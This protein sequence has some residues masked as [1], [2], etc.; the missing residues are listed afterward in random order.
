MTG[1][2]PHEPVPRLPRHAKD[3]GQ[4]RFLSELNDWIARM[5]I[6]ESVSASAA[7]LPLVYVVGAPRSGTT[8]ASQLL[9]KYLDVGYIDNL[10]ARFWRRPIVGIRLS[11][12]CLGAEARRSISLQSTYGV[13]AGL[14]GP[15]E[16]GYFWRYWFD[17]DHAPTH[18][19][20]PAELERVD[21]DG[22]G[23]VLRH[24]LLGGFDRPTVF[25][26]VI[27]GFQARLLSRVHANSLF[28][29]VTRDPMATAGSILAARLARYGTHNAWWS[30]KPGTFDTIS[31]IAEPAAQVAR[32]V[33][34]CRA[35]LAEELASPGVH[36]ITIGYETLC[37]HPDAQLERVCE[38]VRQLGGDLRPLSAVEP[39]EP[40]SGPN[41]P[42]DLHDALTA[43]F[44]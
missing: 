2:D 43:A 17:L 22:L 30:L 6:D 14:A 21:T 19:L 33:L 40:S 20:T 39:L 4:E 8:L 12:I 11:Q 26:N 44:A 15:H 38:A 10:I 35:E 24:E 1:S 25:K 16:F 42:R 28:I 9:A 13:T 7:A 18:H 32:Q 41:L 34:D 23:R 36:A 29:H 37:Q 3:A 31:R 5:P 27:C